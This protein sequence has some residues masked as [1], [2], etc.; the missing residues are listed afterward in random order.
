[1]IPYH[2]D[3]IVMPVIMVQTSSA[4]EKW[5]TLSAAVMDLTMALLMPVIGSALSSVRPRLAVNGTEA[6]ADV[7]D[8][9]APSLFPPSINLSTSSFSTRPFWEMAGLGESVCVCVYVCCCCSHLLAVVVVSEWVSIWCV[10]KEQS[11]S[12]PPQT[13]YRRNSCESNL[14]CA[15]NTLDGNVVL[16]DQAAHGWSHQS[17]KPV[18]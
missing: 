11:Q 15:N 17:L 9:G 7:A 13:P 2:V 18:G 10:W 5:G 1:M 12:I 4:Y 14:A 6:T 8:A 16:T 3:A